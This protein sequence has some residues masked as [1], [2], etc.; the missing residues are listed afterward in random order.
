MGS[1]RPVVSSFSVIACFGAFGVL[2][3]LVTFV[4]FEFF[5]DPGWI[6][7]R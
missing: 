2:V 5:V 6:R 4:L 1:V 7:D 3:P